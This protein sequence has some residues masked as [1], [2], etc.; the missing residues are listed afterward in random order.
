MPPKMAILMGEHDTLKYEVSR[1]GIPLGVNSRV[2]EW[3][4]GSI[5]E[6]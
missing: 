6:L 5:L 4:C 2:L 3:V 1:M